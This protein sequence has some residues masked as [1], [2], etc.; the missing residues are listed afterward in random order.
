LSTGFI[1]EE[2]PQGFKVPAPEGEVALRIVAVGA[3]IDH[4]LNERKREIS[5]QMRHASAVRFERERAVLLGREHHDV[6]VEDVDGGIA[7]VI[8][9][10]AWPVVSSW[11]PG[12][13]V[14]TG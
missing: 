7:I 5:G 9:G 8:D 13:P 4:L 12:E 14:W 3:A 11:R 6:V 10:E 2:Y 1:A